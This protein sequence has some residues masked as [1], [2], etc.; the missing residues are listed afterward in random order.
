MKSVMNNRPSPNGDRQLQIVAR[1]G[2]PD[3]LDLPWFT[4]LSRWTDGRIVKMAHGISRHVVRFVEYNGAVYA[5]KATTA[6]AANLEYQA[7][8]SLQAANLPTVRAVGVVSGLVDEAGQPMSEEGAAS[9]GAGSGEGEGFAEAV[10]IT[11][12]LDYSLP[13]RYVFGRDDVP[14]M[15]AIL[16]D[17]AVV[18]LVRLHLAGAF[19]GDFS[20]SNVLFRR[21]A[22]G[23]MAYLVDAETMELRPTISEGLRVED[24]DIACQ[25]IVG[26]LLD[27]QAGGRVDPGVDPFYLADQ[28]RT[29]Y[30]ELWSELTRT[31]MFDAQERWRIDRRVRHLNSLGFDLQELAIEA[32]DQGRILRITPRVVEEGHCHRELQRRTGLDVQENQARRLLSDIANFGAWLES[33]TGRPVPESV[34]AARWLAEVYEPIVEAIPVGLRDRLEPAEFFHQLLEH[35]YLVSE[36]QGREVTNIEAMDDYLR[37]V[38]PDRPGELLLVDDD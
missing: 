16:R 24:V 18:L 36:R 14:A 37:T 28:F 8:L 17:A 13:Y 35:R 29:R 30:D 22:G 34:A 19:W 1:A 27:L 23:L 4:P 21:D 5:L 25:N 31:D 15:D 32:S 38:L 3:F 10:L 9:D 26:G 6:A 2:H 7:L 20:L 11:R 33:S 12:Y